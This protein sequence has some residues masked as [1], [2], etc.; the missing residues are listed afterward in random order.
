MFEH[1]LDSLALWN[2][3]EGAP[4]GACR[5]QKSGESRR[6]EEAEEEEEEGDQNV[7]ISFAGV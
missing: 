2:E 6:E 5:K 1:A 3:E 7:V 4:N